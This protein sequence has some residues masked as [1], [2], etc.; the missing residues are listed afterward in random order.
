M[1]GR[2]ITKMELM[3]LSLG[4]TAI[5]PEKMHHI[6]NL[7]RAELHI[8]FSRVGRIPSRSELY[9]MITRLFN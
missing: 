5:I 8:I 7:S 2:C 9:V 4:E 1:K 6:R 3:H